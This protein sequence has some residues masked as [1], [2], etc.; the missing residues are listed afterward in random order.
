MLTL[1]FDQIDSLFPFHI[2]VGPDQRVVRRGSVLADCFGVGL[3]ASVFDAFTIVDPPTSDPRP[4]LREGAEYVLAYKPKALSLRGPVVR[5][6]G[7]N[8][9]AFLGAPVIMTEGAL[10]EAA[11][12]TSIHEIFSALETA[13]AKLEA[14]MRERERIANELRLAHRLEAVGQLASGIAHEINTPIQYVS[15]SVHFIRDAVNDVQSIIERIRE[16]RD[17]LPEAVSAEL[18]ELWEE[19]DIDFV[20]EEA[21]NALARAFDGLER[22]ANIVRAMKSFAHPGGDS[23]V[24]I[25]L[26]AAIETT[27][28]VCRNEYKYVADVELALDE[29]PEVPCFPGELNQVILNLVV[30]AAHAVGD[31]VRDTDD[32][33]TIAIRTRR[34]TG[35]VCI[36]IADSGCGIPEPIQ[37]RIFDPFFTTKPVGKGT[38]QGLAISRSIIVKHGGSLDFETA[39]GKGTTFFVRIPLEEAA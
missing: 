32:R 26:N 11:S 12:S 18:D 1:D 25:D 14:E 7:S 34:E 33:G 9:L 39:E 15:D 17:E 3:G 28:T 5:L 10:D 24:A 20:I 16:R 22:V 37:K 21:P 31:V 19:R 27:L 23:K 29:L 38:G 13:N 6:S 36:E 35:T 30:N 4:T 8:D 2:V